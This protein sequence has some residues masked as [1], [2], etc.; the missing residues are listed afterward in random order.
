MGKED[1]DQ[2]SDQGYQTPSSL[3][4]A[5]VMAQDNTRTVYSANAQ[6]QAQLHG[7]APKPKPTPQLSNTQKVALIVGELALIMARLHCDLNPLNPLNLFDL[8]KGDFWGEIDVGE[9][10]L[11]MKLVAPPDKFAEATKN[12]VLDGKT[13]GTNRVFV[14]GNI[15]EAWI[16]VASPELHVGGIKTEAFTS[17]AA[18]LKGFSAAFDYPK[19]QASL[20]ILEATLGTAQLLK[21]TDKISVDSLTI[22]GLHL[23]G[24]KTGSVLHGNMSF[25]SA[26][27]VRLRYPGMPPISLALAGGTSFA[28]VWQQQPKQELP[29]GQSAPTTAAAAP[30]APPTSSKPLGADQMLPA[31]AEIKVS[32]TR[33]HAAA[34]SFSW[35][36]PVAGAAAGI[37]H[38]KIALVRA[39]GLELASLA[40]HDFT[41]AGGMLG[42]GASSS[43]GAVGA[44]GKLEL[45]GDAAMVQTLLSAPVVHPEL[46]S[47]VAAVR[48]LG[49]QPAIGGSVT[50][51]DLHFGGLKQGQGAAARIT[52]DFSS[53]IEVPKLGSLDV[54]LR[55]FDVA[56]GTAGGLSSVNTSFASFTAVLRGDGGGELARLELEGGGVKVGKQNAGTL[57]T[58]KATGD[59]SGLLKA[60]KE[61]MKTAPASVRGALAAVRAL[62]VGVG[63]SASGLSVTETSKGSI[64]YAGDLH[65]SLK[66][67]LGRIAIDAIGVRGTDASLGAMSTFAVTLYTAGGAKA[68]SI[69]ATGL[70]ANVASKKQNAGLH[71]DHL[72]VHGD[73]AQVSAMIAAVR[74]K[75]PG[76]APPVRQ[77]LG[78]VED[79]H[80]QGQLA[81]SV[82]DVSATE[83]K[84][85]RVSARIGALDN[86]FDVPGVG[87]VGLKLRGI[88]GAMAAASGA[89]AASTTSSCGC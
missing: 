63:V 17:G 70:K 65:A 20:S 78:A 18:N 64:S 45:R 68:A 8:H 14:R 31:D 42:S 66:T 69:S 9:L 83:S 55:D 3:Y 10:L 44:I 6:L 62:G 71:A 27:M 11:V 81:L 51:E 4:Q 28:G 75:A 26:D 86:A 72:E 29:A 22:K 61:P 85:G 48:R 39:S 58:L 84:Q 80:L 41:V 47:A 49:I 88:E 37:E 12:I 50:L 87:K 57:K 73:Y 7:Q 19:G 15:F 2:R 33:A 34:A 67:N 52:G 89:A 13:Y 21:G 53:H 54:A 46:A 82:D 35:L 59:V 56:G 38:A 5:P 30:A 60:L 32:I 74:A 36:T 1:K 24:G 43:G 23:D 40:I 16:N 77:A 79:L 76:L 25:V